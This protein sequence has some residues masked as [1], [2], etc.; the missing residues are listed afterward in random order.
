M[1]RCSSCGQCKFWVTVE[2]ERS[3]WELAGDTKTPVAVLA[4][5]HRY[6]TTKVKHADDWCGEFQKKENE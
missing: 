4:V 5:C 1:M 2:T 3:F 6:P